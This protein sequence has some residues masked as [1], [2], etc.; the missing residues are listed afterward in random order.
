[1]Y[2][3]R[4]LLVNNKIDLYVRSVQIKLFVIGIIHLIAFAYFYPTLFYYTV[5]TP[6]MIFVIFYICFCH[7]SLMEEYQRQEMFYYK[8]MLN[9]HPEHAEALTLMI[10]DSTQDNQIKSW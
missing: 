4:F 8:L 3:N 2:N 1:M 10:F 9:K 6:F 5:G 7:H